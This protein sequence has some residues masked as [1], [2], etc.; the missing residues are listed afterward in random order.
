MNKIQKIARKITA[1]SQIVKIV[2]INGNYFIGQITVQIYLQ[3]FTYNVKGFH[4]DINDFVYDVNRELKSIG[5]N[6]I[7][8]QEDL[9]FKKNNKLVEFNYRFNG[10]INDKLKQN[11]MQHEWII[12]E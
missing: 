10:N 6:R 5:I 1:R 11:F 12:K 4:S 9:R 2:A 3:P 7:C 8:K